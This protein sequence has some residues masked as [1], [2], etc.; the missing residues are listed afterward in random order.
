MLPKNLLDLLIW[1]SN[2]MVILCQNPCGSAGIQ[3]DC[4][5]YT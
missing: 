5:F 3:K 2:K 1:I 4:V